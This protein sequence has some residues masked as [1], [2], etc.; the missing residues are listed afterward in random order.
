MNIMQFM[1]GII[2]ISIGGISVEL[3][4]MDVRAGNGISVDDSLRYRFYSGR[5]KEL[6][7]VAAVPKYAKHETPRVLSKRQVTLEKAF[8]KSVA[9]VFDNL[10]FFERVRLIQRGVFF[11]VP[12]KYVFLPFLLINAVDSD[13]PYKS[14]STLL[15]PAQFL[16]LWHIQKS[17]LNGKSMNEIAGI[18][19]MTQSSVSRA[20]TQLNSCGIV[21][22]EKH[23]DRTKTVSFV[24]A[25][26][27]LWDMALPHLFSPV[28]QTW[29]C[30]RLK[31]GEWPKGGI[32]ALSHFSML[33]PAP[34]D[35]LVM[36]REQFNSAK[37]S[38]V[39]LNRI[40]GDIIIEVWK[41]SPL[42]EDGYVDKLSLYLTLMGDL[43][44]RV[45]KELEIMLRKIW[46]T[47]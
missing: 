23:A 8:N 43:D 31:A 2:Q 41:Y 46:Y 14:T 7:F 44:P 24:N 45:E 28:I 5:F 17:L 29:Y 20:L 47:D 25:G 3:I 22:V 18:T 35:T 33:A 27:E 30:D 42:V 36:T 38:I 12:G 32:S 40:D 39:G 21:S 10:L 15:P 6:D 13:S 16:L 1:E 11:I 34:E 19:G 9:F 4:H 37:Q 26:K